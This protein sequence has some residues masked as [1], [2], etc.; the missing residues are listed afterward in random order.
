[1]KTEI[2]C[3]EIGTGKTTF[4]LTEYQ[5]FRYFT[6]DKMDDIK[7]R[8]NTKEFYCIIDSIENIPE[9]IFSTSINKIISA[10]W[11]SIILIFNVEKEK[12]ADCNN[13][14]MLW[15]AGK[16]PIN[17][18]YTNFT[19]KEEVFY[20]YLENNFPNLNRDSYNNIIKVTNYNFNQISR[21]MLL[22]S[23]HSDNEKE[24]SPR[25][26]S[27]YINELTHKIYK[28]IPDADI[29]LQKASLIGEQFTCDALESSDGFGYDAASA[30]IK[31]MNDIHGFIRSC[32][33]FN[34][35]YE[36]ISHDVYESV[37]DTIAYENKVSWVKI[38]I[39]YYKH[40]YERSID[41]CVR[42]TILNRLDSLYKLLPAHTAERKVICFLLFYQY[43]RANKMHYA[44]Q[45]AQEIIDELANELT[46]IEC[47]FIQNYQ[48]NTFFQ[49]WEYSK[50]LEILNV[51]ITSSRYIGS[52]ML[53]KYYYAYCLYQTG[54]VDESYVK[55]K[56]LVNYLKNTSGSNEHSH[57]LFCMTYSLMATL[58]NHLDKADNGFRYYG[59]ALNNASKN[60]KDKY[61]YDILK[62]CD[63]FY[64]Y[65]DIKTSLEECLQFYEEKKDWN[66]AG[67][68]Y[69]NL[70]TE[71]MFQDC[72]EKKKIKQYFE[73]A[74]CCFAENNSKKLV[75]AQN[76]YAIYLIMVE[77]NIKEGLKN[78]K[79]ALL[80]GLSD[81][82]YMCLYLNLCMCHILL[83]NMDSAE[84]SDSYQRFIFAKK[85]LNKRENATKY[86]DIYENIL[87]IIVGEWQ[88][89][90]VEKRCLSFLDKLDNNSFF[91]PLLEDIIKRSRLEDASVHKENTYFYK[92]MNEMHCFLA[93]FRFWE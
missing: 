74:I 65:E 40:Q 49:L 14:N 72:Q 38:L 48:I 3:N 6:T 64:N 29:L 18:K 26:L 33:T 34:S 86:E 91:A 46:P 67:E 82:T 17:Y 61:Y 8:D 58:Q 45:I 50:A 5:P 52:R 22:N 4:A 60:K 59:L 88:G 9:S 41:N 87:R 70:A 77:K 23:L 54:D 68:V 27:R 35:D 12:L 57:E 31:Q 71:M 73:K 85:K 66:S 84:F 62:K 80:V 93:E 2:I 32:I 51:I 10:E 11:K 76:N 1:M 56:E 43:Q 19:A 79:K 78:L 90:N 24:I 75:Y 42:I 16:I 44:L 81:F 25:A 21:L 92:T 13:F 20:A 47:A 30:Y 37:F 39:Q 15:D 89:E 83:R 28:D 55:T 7:D 36:F 69:V 63:M 53:I